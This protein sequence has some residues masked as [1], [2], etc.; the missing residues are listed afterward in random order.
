MVFF[1]L[2]WNP[3]GAQQA[4]AAA[5]THIF[6]RHGEINSEQE[7][8]V[9]LRKSGSQSVHSQAVEMEARQQNPESSSHMKL[10]GITT[11]ARRLS[12]VVGDVW[13]LLRFLYTRARA[14]S[15]F[16]IIKASLDKWQGLFS[17]QT[18]TSAG[19]R[20]CLPSVMD[21]N[22]TYSQLEERNR[23]PSGS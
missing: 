18:V 16:L 6:K 17:I 11:V 4:P 15:S 21:R 3:H 7:L 13:G 5:T 22:K 12:W 2:P 9:F 14:L 1:S 8:D 10:C 20:C 19:P 23:T